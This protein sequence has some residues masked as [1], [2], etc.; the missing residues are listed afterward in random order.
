[1]AKAVLGTPQNVLFL[2]TNLPKPDPFMIERCSYFS[3][4][5]IFVL[6]WGG[7]NQALQVSRE[8]GPGDSREKKMVSISNNDSRLHVPAWPDKLEAIELL[9]KDMPAKGYA[10]T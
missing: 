4:E 10:R 3:H 5:I 9:A 7:G 8:E 2:P 1:M 6:A